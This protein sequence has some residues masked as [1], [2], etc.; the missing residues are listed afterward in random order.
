[1][2]FEVPPESSL[3]KKYIYRSPDSALMAPISIATMHMMQHF[4]RFEL[5]MGKTSSGKQITLVG[6]D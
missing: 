3:I 1:M 4:S 5:R 6:G 2:N